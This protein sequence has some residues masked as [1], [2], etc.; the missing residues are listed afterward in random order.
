MR[1]VIILLVVCCLCMGHGPRVEHF[2]FD[3]ENVLTSAQE[4]RFDSLFRAHEA[5]T[6]NEIALVT[7]NGLKGHLDMQG[8]AAT[9]GDS[10]GVGKRGRNNGV[11]IAFSKQLR[12]VYVSTGLGTERVLTDAHCAQIV[13][14]L[15]I[16]L[17]KEDM[18][19]DGLWLGS[20][21][22]VRHLEKP[23]NYIP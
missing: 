12:S 5:V 13:D 20:L 21:A 1:S 22:I 23:E 17:F 4:E 10:L 18:A 8:F 16:P 14:R 7:T 11:V 19:E 15:M 9:F 3:Q 6:G 2:V